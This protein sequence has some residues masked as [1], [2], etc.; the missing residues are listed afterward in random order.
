MK[1]RGVTFVAGP[2]LLVADSATPSDDLL[3]S[4]LRAPSLSP[5]ERA[6]PARHVRRPRVTPHLRRRSS[7]TPAFAHLSNF[8][9]ARVLVRLTHRP[10]TGRMDGCEEVTHGSG[11][12]REVCFRALAGPQCL[13]PR[14]RP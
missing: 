2:A 6:V 1:I 10:H 4:G 5:A 11:T 7:G 8:C 3:P 13:S 9:P 14:K 12:H